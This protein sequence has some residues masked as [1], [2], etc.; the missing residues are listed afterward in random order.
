MEK[1]NSEPNGHETENG[2][3]IQR[4]IYGISPFLDPIRILKKTSLDEFLVN[5]AN[6]EAKIFKA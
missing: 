2:G 6:R 4:N 3:Y 1:S 5:G